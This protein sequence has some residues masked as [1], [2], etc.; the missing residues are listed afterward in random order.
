[1]PVTT[2]MAW[3]L[4]WLNIPTLWNDT[5]TIPIS[6]YDMAI[7]IFNLMGDRALPPLSEN[8]VCSLLQDFSDEIPTQYETAV[9]TAYHYNFIT[10]RD[11]GLFDGSASLTRGDAA[12]VLSVLVKNDLISVETVV[13]CNTN[14]QQPDL[15]QFPDGQQLDMGQLPS[16]GSGQMSGGMV[17]QPSSLTVVDAQTLVDTIISPVNYTHN[18]VDTLLWTQTK[19]FFTPTMGLFPRL[20]WVTLFMDKMPVILGTNQ[21]TQIIMTAQ[22]LIMSQD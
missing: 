10:G 11:G 18:L 19:L 15:G 8:D 12:V 13:A 22:F 4:L 21:A 2:V 16:G 9:A 5:V 3:F 6:H 1:M 14:G 7:M 17:A 20:T